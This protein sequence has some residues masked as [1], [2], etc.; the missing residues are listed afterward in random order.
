MLR[1]ELDLLRYTR[2][3]EQKDALTPQTTWTDVLRG[4]EEAKVA[5]TEVVQIFHSNLDYDNT[6]HPMYRHVRP[7]LMDI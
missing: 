7:A 5:L 1:A 3:W 6:I 2:A 4:C